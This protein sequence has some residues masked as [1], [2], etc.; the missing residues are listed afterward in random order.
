MLQV[1]LCN[2]GVNILPLSKQ[3]LA[4]FYLLHAVFVNSINFIS[5]QQIVVT[6][7]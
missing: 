2:I 5:F 3:T 7:L 6:A 4:L 1:P